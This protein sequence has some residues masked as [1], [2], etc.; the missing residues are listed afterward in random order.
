[1]ADLCTVL[2]AKAQLNKS[3][4]DSSDDVE[5]AIYIAAVTELIEAITGPVATRTVVQNFWPATT[6]NALVL[7]TWPILTVTSIVDGLTGYD[8]SGWFVADT[9][10][11]VLHL[12]YP[13][14]SAFPLQTS[15]LAVTYTAGR[16]SIPPIIHLAALLAV[17]DLWTTQQGRSSTR[18]LPGGDPP[19][20]SAMG[21][22][23][24]RVQELLVPYRQG[25]AF[26]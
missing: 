24:L 19:Q 14:Y 22:L 21:V 5:L 23:P 15:Y 1:M 18:P 4:L 16:A 12:K 25:P 7:N 11:G 8:M 2:E 3:A 20:A 17:S 9:P 6:G 10:S 26:A 13:G